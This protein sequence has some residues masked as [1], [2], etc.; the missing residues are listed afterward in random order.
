MDTTFR[1]NSNEDCINT[2]L[3]E[4]GSCEFQQY[5]QCTDGFSQ[6]Q[7]DAS[8]V[9]DFHCD[10]L[11]CEDEGFCNNVT[12]G[13]Y[14]YKSYDS[15]TT[16][17]VPAIFICDDYPD[18]ILGEDEKNCSENMIRICNFYGLNSGKYVDGKRQISHSQACAVPQ[19]EGVCSDGL[20]QVN[21]TDP[22]R[23]AL[24]CTVNSFQ[25]TVSIF[26]I[27]KNYFI[28][29]DGYDSNCV[30]PEGGCIIHKNQLCDGKYDCAGHQDEENAVC[31]RLTNVSCNR[32]VSFKKRSPLPIPFDWVFDGIP[33]CLNG[34]DEDEQ[35]WKKCGSGKTA[36]FDEKG[37]GCSDILKCSDWTGFIELPDI[38][39]KISSC[40][41]EIAM[42]AKS[43][44][45]TKTFNKVLEIE[46]ER[47]MYGRRTKVLAHCLKGLEGLS[48]MAGGCGNKTM[49]KI[50]GSSAK[51]A[52]KTYLISPQTPSHCHGMFGESYVYTSCTKSCLKATCPL[53]PIPQDTCTNK[54]QKKVYSLTPSNQLQLL[55]RQS[56]G[57][58]NE[59][60]PCDNK[61]CV[62]YSK[63]CNLVDDCGDDSDERGC[64]NHFFCTSSH[65]YIPSSSKCDGFY[66]CKDFEDE[67]NE[68]CN[69]SNRYI[70][71]NIGLKVSTW[72]IGGLAVTF[73][74]FAAVRTL[75]NLRKTVTYGGMMNRVLIL[76]VSIGDF[77]MG[78]YL[79]VIAAVDASQSQE[80][81]A[82]KFKW[83]ASPECAVLGILNTIASQLSLFSMTALS[84]F[85]FFSVGSMIQSG[86]DSLGRKLKIIAV[87]AGITMLTV[88]LAIFP[89]M[90]FSEDFF[91]NGLYYEGNPLFTASV[92]K[93]IHLDVFSEHYG[94]SRQGSYSSWSLIR[95]MVKEMFTE[96]YG[97]EWHNSHDYLRFLSAENV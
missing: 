32:R 73:N 53:R 38:C 57:Y 5:F 95:Q 92:S 58:T 85:R 42:C 31:Q 27:C 56:N 19:G 87:T 20:D 25:T 47:G 23:I 65:E 84:V 82:K 64:N 79:I 18:C 90:K 37:R 6:R 40:G 94:R 34:E 97:G 76:L 9:C 17:Y 10:C 12:Y 2:D 50:P 54:L 35:Y 13:I 11:T 55:L 59:L 86:L 75:F 49:F 22:T 60:F 24:T 14:C 52:T 7:I 48:D 83:L 29:D 67:C 66:D 28:C 69:P 91:V 3:D 71:G 26:G 72:V 30:Q 77:L 44:G 8:S 68:E 70:L 46:I 88:L 21:C 78:V 63:V 15:N 4:Q 43:R 16:N 41:R 33:D 1:C 61:N 39:D 62:M 81:C 74:G 51:Y 96:D 80:Y 93:K 36:R 89:V 45:M